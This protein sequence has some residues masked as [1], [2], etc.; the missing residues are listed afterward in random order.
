MTLNSDQQQQQCSLRKILRYLFFCLVL[1]IAVH[2]F[3]VTFDLPL[4]EYNINT[5][6]VAAKTV[7]TV[8]A[9]EIEITTNTSTISTSA[10]ASASVETSYSTATEIPP[11]PPS[12]ATVTVAD[13]ELTD[14]KK[15]ID[16]NI[17]LNS[18][19][20]DSDNVSDNDNE[21]DGGRDD[22]DVGDNVGAV[23]VDDHNKNAV[24][25][26]SDD[27][28]AREEC[29]YHYTYDFDPLPLPSLV[30][31]GPPKAGSRSFQNLLSRYSNIVQFGPERD[32][33]T[34]ANFYK[35]QLPWKDKEWTQF[36]D[37]YNRS[38][39][40]LADLLPV[41]QNTRPKNN[42][43][44]VD[45]YERLWRKFNI[46]L[47]TGYSERFRPM[48]NESKKCIHPQYH[49][50]YM[51]RTNYRHFDIPNNRM[52][53]MQMARLHP[54]VSQLLADDPDNDHNDGNYS[55]Q[56]RRS[57]ALMA[58]AQQNEHQNA[59]HRQSSQSPSLHYC[60]LI[61][62]GPTYARQIFPSII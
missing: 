58:I 21:T 6:S 22:D 46:T 17:N 8:V 20:N 62:K 28:N 52:H 56:S 31:T 13:T 45:W 4:Q 41:M 44:N 29:L 60:F 37:A 5:V 10:S 23:D 51:N 15:N 11:K 33:F 25:V 43:C 2:I 47:K 42:R 32:F 12:T 61:E 40:K 53:R 39:S 19:L 38:E 49:P 54:S 50:F 55:R 35:C 24:V 30:L 27:N 48:R 7:E 26:V 3:T 16:I 36:L 34:G 14:I 1:G 18:N 9:T 59:D 57:N